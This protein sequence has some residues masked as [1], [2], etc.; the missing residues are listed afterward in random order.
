MTHGGE[1]AFA[2][3]LGPILAELRRHPGGID[4]F[5]LIRALQERNDL[6]E[7]APAAL[8]EPLSLYRA[9]FV[10][11]HCLY[12]L[13]ERLAADGEDVE[14]YCLRI[15]ILRRRDPGP[16]VGAADPMRA[17]YLDLGNLENMDAARVE[18]M[19]GDF[20]LRLA[21]DD[22]REQALATLG[23]AD[24]VTDAEI[25]AAYR[26]LAM[27]HHPDR[28][29]DKAALQRLNEAVKVLNV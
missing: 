22:R 7:F 12:R 23:L 29:G 2:H 8:R 24:P 15:R 18:A 3:L 25:K 1:D 21:R 14:V 26:R 9:H 20:W 10:L 5:R 28:G 13:G 4:E 16:G 6:A 19:L 17:F 27:R 11:F